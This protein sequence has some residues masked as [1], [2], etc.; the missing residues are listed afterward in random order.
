[1]SEFYFVEQRLNYGAQ[2]ELKQI[3]LNT[4]AWFTHPTRI[5]RA[6]EL[7]VLLYSKIVNTRFSLPFQQN[8]PF[9]FQADGSFFMS[10]S[11]ALGPAVADLDPETANR[12]SFTVWGLCMVWYWCGT[13]K[14]VVWYF[15][16][17]DC[18]HFSIE[19]MSP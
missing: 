14:R 3:V 10:A 2:M 15:E 7:R 18:C 4:A 19:C 13:L 1:M 5:E 8:S 6:V 12:I 17:G 11:G 16:E 9:V